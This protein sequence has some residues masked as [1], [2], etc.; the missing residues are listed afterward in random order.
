MAF[1]LF[2]EILSY[3]AV[4]ACCIT[5]VLSNFVIL[6]RA[7]REWEDNALNLCR[8]AGLSNVSVCLALMGHSSHSHPLRRRFFCCLLSDWHS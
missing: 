8:S 2:R 5:F 6:W 7:L 3:C 1:W 4:T